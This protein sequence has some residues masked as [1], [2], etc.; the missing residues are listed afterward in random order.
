MLLP[1]DPVSDWYALPY[2]TDR[3][4]RGDTLS[5]GRPS[6]SLASAGASSWL[7]GIIWQHRPVGQEVRDWDLWPDAEPLT[8]LNSRR[9]VLDSV[10]TGWLTVGT[11]AGQLQLRLTVLHNYT[12]VRLTVLHNYTLVR[13]TVLCNYTLV[14]LT[15]LCNYTLVRLTVLWLTVLHNY[16][17]VRLTVLWLTVLCNY[18]LVRQTVLW[19]TV[20]HNYT[21]VRLTVLC[22]YTLVRLTVLWLYCVVIHWCGWLYCDCTV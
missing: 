8:P 2:P 19:L 21:L 5:H 18:T 15:V 12:L 1:T 20:L 11:R 17:L 16:T 22:N 3:L 9:S 14:R 6:S 13:L 7:R 10:T 4:V